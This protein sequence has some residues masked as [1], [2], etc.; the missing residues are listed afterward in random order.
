MFHLDFTGQ[1]YCTEALRTFLVALFETQ[2]ERLDVWVAI[3]E[4]NHRSRRVVEKCGFKLQYPVPGDHRELEE[5]AETELRLALEELDLPCR[6][7]VPSLSAEDET[8][9]KGAAAALVTEVVESTR[10]MKLIQYYYDK[11]A[12]RVPGIPTNQHQQS[13]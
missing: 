2:K 3:L 13:A 12:V 7:V 6:P 8:L 4:T 1:G 10:R 5:D 9:L 11:P